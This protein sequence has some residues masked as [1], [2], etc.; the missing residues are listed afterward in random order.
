MKN[1]NYKKILAIVIAST[2]IVTTA[3]SV[4]VVSKIQSANAD[5]E[6]TTTQSTTSSD[7]NTQ[8]QP[9]QMQTG[10]DGTMTPPEKPDGDS[11]NSQTPPE[12]PD[13]DSS[14]NQGGPSNGQ[15]GPGGQSSSTSVTYSS[16]TTF[17]KSTTTTRK[18][19]TSKKS[20]QNAVMATGST[21]KV[22]LN[23]AKITKSGSSSGG[24]SD[25]FYGTN[26]AAIAKD[27]ATLT[28][29][30]A[31]IKTTADGAN[32][33][34]AYGGNGGQNGASG[35]G[36]TIKI[37]NSKITTTGNNAGGIMTTGGGTTI[38]T[39]LTVKTS[40]TSSAAIRSDRGG[41]TVKV[42]K[43]TYTTTGTGS[44]AIYCTS[45]TSVSNA[46][47]E[48]KAS[49]G[50]VIEGKNSVTLKNTKLIANNTKLN[51]Q[52]TTYQA[53]MLYQSMS[54]DSAEGTANFSATGGSITNKNGS[55]F[56]VTNTTAKINLNN[57]T[58][59]NTDSDNVLLKVAAG[60]WG[61]SGSNGG[62]VTFTAK[63]QKLS[64]KI[65][66]DDVSSLSLKLTKKSSFTGTINSSKQEGTVKVTVEKGSTWT[67]TGDSYVTSLTN[68]GTINT[69]GHTLYVNGVAY[70]G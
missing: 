12:K 58:I 5:T 28:I 20:G 30:N 35:D 2:A 66:V 62:N 18:T 48:S 4:P 64:G 69:N 23:K 14:N 56:Y 70:K 15:G 52:A 45:N 54:G 49:E 47:L 9:P 34:F 60:A 3:V 68:N 17:K 36:S 55:V 40:G 22:T 38:A 21:T 32:G 6:T 8:G 25:N 39:N 42:N 13:G 27:G 46:T 31:T 44:P 59:K 61:T 26:S 53:I 16:A 1:R 65:T 43:G 19:Y 51:G 33:T 37:S 63:N 24:D 29:K 10:S 57:V 7:G 11:S 67:L 50:I 41:G